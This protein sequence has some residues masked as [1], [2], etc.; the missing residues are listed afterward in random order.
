MSESAAEQQVAALVAAA[1]TED[2]KVSADKHAAA[3]GSE[4]APAVE[5]PAPAAKHAAPAVEEAAAE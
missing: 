4:V 2:A 5:A 1:S 3:L